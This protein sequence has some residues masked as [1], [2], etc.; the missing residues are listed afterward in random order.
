MLDPKWIRE[1][2][3]TVRGLLKSRNHAFDLD[4]LLTLEARRRETLVRVEEL[5]SI[6]NEGSRH[7]GEIKKS[8]GDASRLMEKMKEEGER[9]K[10]L[11]AALC[12]I[13]ENLR[14]QLLMMPNRIHESVPVGRD[15]N[16]NA[17]LKK[18]GVPR[19]FDFEPKPHWELGEALGIMDFETGAR[20]AESRF[21]VLKNEGARVDK[22]HAR[23]SHHKA[24]VYG[25]NASHSR[26]FLHDGGNGTAPQV[27]RR[28]V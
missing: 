9:I 2:P 16:D 6:R 3:D 7:I 27:R 21:T 19:V 15:E 12:E 20:M 25:N 23:P 28:S 13:E 26:K 8:G 17:E 1:N 22:F 11:D 5:K 10:E 14:A 4:A 18:W 24:R